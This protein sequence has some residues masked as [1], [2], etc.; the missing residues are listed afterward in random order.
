MIFILGGS[1]FKEVRQN[2]LDDKIWAIPAMTPGSIILRGAG[3]L[4]SV[5]GNDSAP[6]VLDLGG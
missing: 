5:E 4:Y 1:E 2:V 3:Y 6:V